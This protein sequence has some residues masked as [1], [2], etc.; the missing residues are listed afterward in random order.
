MGRRADVATDTQRNR[1]T[2]LYREFGPVAYR[3]CLRLLCDR[4]AAQDATQEVFVKLLESMAQLE[5]RETVLPWIYRVATNHCLNLL[6]DRRHH[7]EEAASE[8]QNALPARDGASRTDAFVDWEL[9]RTVLARFDGTTQAVAV[10]I[11]VDGMNHDEV[12][13]ALGISRRTV[14]RKLERF[15]EGARRFLGVE[16]L[17]HPEGRGPDDLGRN[18]ADVFLRGRS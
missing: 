12:A 3:R 11:F 5:N 8:D 18:P 10:G 14:T 16:G 6:R 2:R 4:S 9:A 1:V 17:L 13:G 7:R 15:V